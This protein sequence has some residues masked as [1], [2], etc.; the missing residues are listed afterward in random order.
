FFIG[1]RYENMNQ[2]NID[3]SSPGGIHEEIETD[4]RALYI[5]AAIIH[6]HLINQNVY[7]PFGIHGNFLIS[8]K[9]SGYKHFDV[10]GSPETFEYYTNR[11]DPNRK[12]FYLFAAAGIGIKLPANL[13]AETLIEFG[14]SQNIKYNYSLGA[15]VRLA[16]TFPNRDSIINQI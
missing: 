2:F 3:Y 11:S 14:S 6:K 4:Q 7:F 8:N 5:Q 9:H 15:S 10:I 16:W 12:A 13:H 1:L